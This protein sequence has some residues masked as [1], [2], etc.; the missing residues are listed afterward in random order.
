[1]GVRDFKIYDT[2]FKTLKSNVLTVAKLSIATGYDNCKFIKKTI[3][4][5]HELLLCLASP[6]CV[7]NN[8]IFQACFMTSK[9]LQS[10]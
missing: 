4:H 10:C 7:K 2:V 3:V 1:M 5:L 6:L 8:L 9:M